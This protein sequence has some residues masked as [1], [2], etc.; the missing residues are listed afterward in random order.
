[1]QFWFNTDSYI[2]LRVSF[3]QSILIYFDHLDLTL[4]YYTFEVHNL[5]NLKFYNTHSGILSKQLYI[6]VGML[7]F[8]E[9]AIRFILME[10]IISL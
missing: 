1:M 6:L 9:F 10:I 3:D 7:K 5:N 8:L 2:T 4:P